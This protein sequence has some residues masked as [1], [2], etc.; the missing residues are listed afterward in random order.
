M[1]DAEGRFAGATGICEAAGIGSDGAAVFGAADA[2]D[3][4]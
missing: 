4:N 2:S 3:A 1:L